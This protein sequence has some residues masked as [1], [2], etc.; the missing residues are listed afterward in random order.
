M[1]IST[2][3][4]R[5]Q[6]QLY[7]LGYPQPL[8]SNATVLVSMLLKDMQAALGRVKELEAQ[9]T[10]LERDDRTSRATMSKLKT[11]IHSLRT[12][13]NTLRS[14]VL[15]YTRE[16]DQA[17]RE[18]RTRV[19]E[20]EK[21]VDDLRMAQLRMKAE[22]AES[23]R[24][25]DECQ[26]KLA[27]SV[28]MADPRGRI[29]RITMSEPLELSSKHIELFE[30]KS[31]VDLVDLSSRRIHALE[32]EVSYLETKL[33]A[34][35]SE[36]RAA[37]LEVKERDL[38]LIRLNN[39]L[40]QQV[41]TAADIPGSRLSDQVN[42]LH[43]RAE[44]LER[45]NKEMREQFTRE[46]DE[47]HKRWV[48]TENERAQLADNNNSY[49]HEA[50]GDFERIREIVQRL[51]D[52]H[53]STRP[54]ADELQNELERLPRNSSNS[55]PNDADDGEMERLRTEHANIKSLY[56]QTRDQL[57]E[58]LKSGN[59]D[60]HRVREQSRE[61]ENKLRT[62]MEQS[63][64]ETNANAKEL[65]NE[66]DLKDKQIKALEQ[67]LKRQLKEL[68]DSD[69]QHREE[70]ERLQ[71]R[72]GKLVEF[73]VIAQQHDSTL[74]E[75]QRLVEQHNKV[76]Q[77]LR[78][79]LR[80][81]SESRSKIS[82]LEHKVSDLTRRLS[83]HKMLNKQNS[84]ELKSCRKTL[85]AYKRDTETMQQARETAKRDTERL[86]AELNQ[87]ARLRDAVEMAKDE[88]KAQLAKSL[89]EN[90]AHRGLAAHLMAE[91]D[92][93]RAQVKAQFHLNQR[94]EQRLQV[95]EHRT[96]PLWQ[97][98]D[99]IVLNELPS[100]SADSGRRISGSSSAHS[101]RSFTRS[102]SN[103]T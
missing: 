83:D 103:S 1:S 72:V 45:E 75:C 26:K 30:K 20:T 16:L 78:E 34:T 61:A 8:P 25:L 36:L 15:N 50:S 33:E 57:Q 17:G 90:E 102:D 12:E 65:Q 93:L 19:Y 41:P 64:A 37:Q 11:E 67:Q 24:L 7:L 31:T 86:K 97:A 27:E 13:N 42:Y 68:D 14:E 95:V 94:L 53:P 58:L 79:A 100:L 80:E 47:L 39:E 23:Q 18:Q 62:D 96:G 4:T 43:E 29:A 66:I 40:E 82:R 3:H 89:K 51:R 70:R 35:G 63:I 38:E 76:D 59:A 46:K 28:A 48:Q 5:L 6:R 22:C 52:S 9:S 77:S 49:K 55:L 92:A 88:Y 54:L 85:D 32:D 2:D 99:S 21:K 71:K 44:Q 60:L 10:Q 87:L 69:R 91:R 84:N 81:V 98:P 101:S 73:E 56:A 74:R